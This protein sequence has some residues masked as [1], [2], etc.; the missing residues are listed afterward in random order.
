MHKFY[1][2]LILILLM[3]YVALAKDNNDLIIP[4]PYII[5][6]SIK[7]KLCFFETQDM[8]S[9]AKTII[10][11]IAI[12]INNKDE[13][14]GVVI[15]FSKQV[16]FKDVEDS[17]NKMFAKYSQKTFMDAKN[18]RIW[19]VEN[20]FAIQLALS[21]DTVKLIYISLKPEA[22]PQDRGFCPKTKTKELKGKDWM[23][24]AKFKKSE[25]Q[26]GK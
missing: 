6:K 10:D 12:D 20:K 4:S 2:I 21:D 15:S 11:N 13:I 8:E 18:L 23:E 5:G 7:T 1:N 25:T 9:K 19:K 22:V 16:K 17:I 3:N 14:Y 24:Q 26:Q